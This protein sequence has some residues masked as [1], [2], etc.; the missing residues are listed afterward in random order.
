METGFVQG[1][2]MGLLRRTTNPNLQNPTQTEVPQLNFDA[3]CELQSVGVLS[4]NLLR[5]IAGGPVYD[6]CWPLGNPYIHRS[7]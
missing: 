1:L 2:G 7:S 3:S 4:R 5:T 6:S